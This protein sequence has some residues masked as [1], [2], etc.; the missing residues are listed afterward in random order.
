[1]QIVLRAYEDACETCV[2]RYDGY[3]FRILGDGIVAFFGFPLAHESE[4]ERAVRAGLDIIDAIARLNLRGVG[5]LQVRIGITSG[6]VV[7][8][9]GERN[10][11]C[12]TINLAARLQTI[13]KPGSVVVSE[14]VRRMAG[15]EFEYEDL[16]EKELKGVSRLTKVYRVLDVGRAESRFEAATC[17]LDSYRRPRH[18][19]RDFG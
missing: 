12:G 6:V 19:N 14:N 16:G 17:P 3:V 13:A 2:N 11:V 9:S 4:A 10:A 7:I 18:R 5:R 1:M 15:G 8:A